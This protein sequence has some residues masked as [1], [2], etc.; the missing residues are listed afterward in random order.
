MAGAQALVLDAS[1]VVKW[2]VDEEF[3]SQ[4]L[5]IRDAYRQRSV[6]VIEPALLSFEVLNAL[7]YK[8]DFGTE[9]I[10]SVAKSLTGFQFHIFLLDGVVAEKTA[11]I[12]FQFGLTIYDASYF[13]LAVQ[14]S[15]TFVT[16][17]KKLMT[18]L[19]DQPGIRHLKDYSL[20]TATSSAPNT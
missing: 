9:D 17:E 18:K 12:A 5:A 4:A 1:V 11:E 16:A 20:P 14:Q 8:P 2:F 6:D 19:K 15:C 13:A 7:R 10:R 3:T